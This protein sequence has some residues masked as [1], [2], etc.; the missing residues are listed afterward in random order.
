MAKRSSLLLA[1]GLLLVAGAAVAQDAAQ[2][3][4]KNKAP[5]E[6]AGVKA[7]VQGDSTADV[8]SKCG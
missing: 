2:E 7:L 4:D 8:S 5:G 1:L 3:C 6:I